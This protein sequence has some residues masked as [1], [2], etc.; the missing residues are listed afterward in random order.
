MFQAH[1][2]LFEFSTI[3]IRILCDPTAKESFAG[4]L[5]SEDLNVTIG[6]V[7]RQSPC[8]EE[9][10]EPEVL[11]SLFSISISFVNHFHLSDARLL[12]DIL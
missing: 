9:Y 10:L 1:K 6:W 3:S 12:E 2:A 8:Y 7:V 5:L 4:D 11:V